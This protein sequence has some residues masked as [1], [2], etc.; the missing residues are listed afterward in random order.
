MDNR[1]WIWVGLFGGVAT[2]L[3]LWL[4]LSGTDTKTEAAI[5]RAGRADEI[6][7]PN[8]KGAKTTKGPP[9]LRAVK[10]DIDPSKLTARQIAQRPRVSLT[11]IPAERRA[12]R[13]QPLDGDPFPLDSQG[14]ADAIDARREDLQACYE[15][16]LF[17]TPDLEGSM[18]LTLVV[19]PDDEQDASIVSSVKTSSDLD[20]TILEGCI[21]TVFEELRFQKGEQTTINYPVNL[22]PGEDEE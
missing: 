14:I 4:L 15:T 19:E 21:A 9:A 16:A 20:A 2:V 18:V 3:L 11:P 17:H 10:A 22:A 12:P 8:F 6:A 13:P 7:A 5:Q 1:S